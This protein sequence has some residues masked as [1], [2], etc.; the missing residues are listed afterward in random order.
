MPDV[1]AP[2]GSGKESACQM[3]L[4]SLLNLYQ[5]ATCPPKFLKIG[6]PLFPEVEYIM[7]WDRNQWRNNGVKRGEEVEERGGEK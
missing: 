5:K 3:Q 7:G 6:A 4:S 2:M 1:K